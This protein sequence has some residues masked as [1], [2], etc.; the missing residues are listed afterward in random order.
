MR[1]GLR[2]SDFVLAASVLHHVVFFALFP[3][4]TNMSGAETAIFPCPD[5][6]R[7]DPRLPLRIRYYRLSP[8]INAYALVFLSMLFHDIVAG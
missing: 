4:E 6:A 5:C 8:C 2:H 7:K 3:S 1:G